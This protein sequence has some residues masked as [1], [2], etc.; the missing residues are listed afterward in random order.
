MANA[1]DDV[2]MSVDDKVVTRLSDFVPRGLYNSVLTDKENL[3][4][5]MDDKHMVN[6]ITR[7]CV[8]Y[9]L[10][11]AVGKAS[12]SLLQLACLCEMDADRAAC[13]ERC[14]HCTDGQ[15]FATST[16]CC[17][18]KRHIIDSLEWIDAER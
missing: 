13:G 5:D 7:E 16:R 18:S 12:A 15:L 1:N 10:G 4:V 9:V 6:D 8:A 17:L 3:T 2:D 14:E 11:K